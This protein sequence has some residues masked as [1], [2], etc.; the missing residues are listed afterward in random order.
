MKWICIY[1]LSITVVAINAFPAII[2][3]N[4]IGFLER[5]HYFFSH[6]VF[7]VSYT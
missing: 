6:I 5:Q 7:K 2:S 1:I 4:E 3:N